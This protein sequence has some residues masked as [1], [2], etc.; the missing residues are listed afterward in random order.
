MK[1]RNY[2]DPFGSFVP[3]NNQAEE[4]KANAANTQRPAQ[5]LP[6]A[7]AAKIAEDFGNADPAEAERRA[8]RVQELRAQ[9]EAGELKPADSKLVAAKF[10][11]ELMI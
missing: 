3:A 10:I 1:V 6:Q 9:R 2:S 5:S 8:K 7:E 4:G 11:Q